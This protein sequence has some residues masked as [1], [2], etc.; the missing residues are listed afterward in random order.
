MYSNIKVYQVDTKLS[1]WKIRNDIKFN[2]K[3]ISVE[4]KIEKVPRDIR[5]A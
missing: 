3:V 2:Q 4:G 1:L 5:R